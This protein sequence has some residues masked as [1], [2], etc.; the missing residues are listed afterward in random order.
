MPSNLKLHASK[1]LK[2]NTFRAKI[3][4]R[5]VNNISVDNV[6]NTICKYIL[7]MLIILFISI[8]K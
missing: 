7:V 4:K 2:V 3:R 1:V 6:N 5:Y 8:F